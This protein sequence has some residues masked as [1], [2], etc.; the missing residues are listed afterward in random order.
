MRSLEELEHAVDF[1]TTT[2]FDVHYRLRPHLVRIA[3]HR[4]AAGHGVLLEADPE[5]ARA[6]LGEN[7][8]ELVRADREPPAD[9]NARGIAL[10]R[11][12]AAVER[13]EAL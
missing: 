5:A 6:L 13:L 9:R 8:W 3:R 2:A 1:A 4:L 12:A 11:V 10:G 7:L